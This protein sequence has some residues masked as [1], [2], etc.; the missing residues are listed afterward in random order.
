VIQRGW[1]FAVTGLFLLELH[2]FGQL[3]PEKRRLIQL[4]YNQPLEGHAPIAGYGFFY[5]NNP[6]F[7]NT[8]MT[9][10]LAVA[11]V[12]IDA[13]LG[14]KGVLT[15]N[16]DISIGVAGGGF[17]DTYSEI[18]DGQYLK[19]ESFWG[20]SAEISSS[21]YQRLNPDWRVP[22]WWIGRVSFHQSF[23]EDDGDTA[24][25][26]KVPD[27]VGSF[28]V[29]TGFRLGG[30]EPMINT[31]VALELSVWYAGQFRNNAQTYGFNDRQLESATHHFWARTLLK[32][33]FEESQQYFDVGLT[34]GT[35][36]HA[37]RL[38]AYRLGGML[39]FVS[40]FPLSIPGYFYQEVS[41]SKFG[42]LTA[43]YSFPI[44][45]NKNWRL[46]L[47]GATALVDYL[48]GLE[49]P[50]NWQSGVG[51]GVTWVS[52]RGSWLVSLLYGYGFNAL[53]HGEEGANQIGFLFQ[54]DFDAVK[55]YRFRR[56]EP[57][58]SPYSSKGG[59]R[60]FQ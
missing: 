58:I 36:I 22:V 8:N 31:P 32:Y 4:A 46:S 2:V 6:E 21:I 60:I 26:F 14:F 3:D 52:P 40:E 24:P 35:S 54:Y 59:E 30:K 20:H 57:E 25:N 13:E 45:P 39:P 33:T 5:Y 9:L 50:D 44:T 17:A 23:Y 47:Y 34:L 41:A 19:E 38:G 43:E 51:A 16:T 49:L 15:P 18:R 10:R 56:F 11:P 29:R 48:P 27:D 12:Y 1:V 28:N 55:K 37:D 42:L 7:I 53:R